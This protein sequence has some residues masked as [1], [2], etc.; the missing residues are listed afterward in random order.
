MWQIFINKTTILTAKP[1]DT[2]L[3]IKSQLHHQQGI[4][5]H[6]Q[7]LIFNGRQLTN[8]STLL[9]NNIL[10]NNTLHLVLR[11]LG[12]GAD[13]GTAATNRKYLRAANLG[14]GKIEK[15]R[16]DEENQRSEE[17]TTCALSGAPLIAP[18]CADKLGYLYNKDAVINYLLMDKTV[19]SANKNASKFTHI[20][21][22]L[23]KNA[24]VVVCNFTAAPEASS[25]SSTSTSSTSSSETKNDDSSSSDM[26]ESSTA[27]RVI[28][29]VTLRP[30]NQK[31]PFVIVWKTGQVYSKQAIRELPEACGLIKGHGEIIIPLAPTPIQ[32]EELLSKIKKKRK[33]KKKKGDGGSSSTSSSTS[34]TRSVSA[35][36]AAVG[37]EAGPRK[38]FKGKTAE[39]L[40]TTGFGFGQ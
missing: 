7:R 8:E 2:I 39:E 15:S 17:L 9:H 4:P 33:R 32:R 27:L 24:S 14:N 30:M 34:S 3:S 29:P 31:N 36:F 16:T 28:C 5:I 12:G 20:R 10:Q 40:F 11:L 22:L 21:K 35:T 25:S 13:G 38:K 37:S 18:I 23:G 1:T 26:D 19:R 6:H